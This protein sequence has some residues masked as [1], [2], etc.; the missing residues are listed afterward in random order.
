LNVPDLA[1]LVMERTNALAQISD[2][3]GRLTRTFSL[4]AMR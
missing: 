3:E 1:E 2:D 4:P